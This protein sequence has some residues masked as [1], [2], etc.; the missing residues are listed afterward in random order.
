MLCR[1]IFVSEHSIIGPP[2][3]GI[4]QS[5]GQRSRS[6]ALTGPSLQMS[7]WESVDPTNVHSG[8]GTSELTLLQ[9]DAAVK[10]VEAGVLEAVGA[11]DEV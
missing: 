8:I 1:V 7:V 5:R 6:D 11:D 2:T 10:A 4:E 3:K 9:L